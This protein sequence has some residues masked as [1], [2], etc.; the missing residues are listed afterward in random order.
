MSKNL[1]YTAALILIS[2]AI[3]AA[4]ATLH[5]RYQEDLRVNAKIRAHLPLD[6]WECAGLTGSQRVTYAMRNPMRPDPPCESRAQ[7]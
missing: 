6:A 4:G 7:P 3:G 1:S 2:V 5:F